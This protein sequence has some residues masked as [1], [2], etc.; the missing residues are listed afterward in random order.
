MASVFP[1]SVIVSINRHMDDKSN[2]LTITERDS[3][4]LSQRYKGMVCVVQNT[5]TT[6]P[7][8][9]GLPDGNNLTN[10]GW[11]EIPIGGDIDLSDNIYIHTQNTAELSWVVPH[12][13]DFRRPAVDIFDKDGNKVLIEIQ[14]TSVNIATINWTKPMT[15]SAIFRKY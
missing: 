2:K 8:I 13:L 1:S 12:N 11:V 10:S 9:F 6:L 15:G 4:P 7:Q 14:Y 5:G 3:I